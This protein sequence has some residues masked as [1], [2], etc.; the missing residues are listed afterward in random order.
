[1]ELSLLLYFITEL[2]LF[3]SKILNEYFVRWDGP[4]VDE[5]IYRYKYQHE[6]SS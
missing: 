4:I 2:K 6:A 3:I 1:M 5:L